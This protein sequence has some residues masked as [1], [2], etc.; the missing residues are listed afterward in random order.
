MLLSE[1]LEITEDTN[2]NGNGFSLDCRDCGPALHV[3]NGAKVNFTDV[4]FLRNFNS[5]LKTSGVGT[6]V[7]WNSSR[8]RGYIRSGN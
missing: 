5:W 4:R 8:M 6:E 1:T 2:I 7:T 3:S